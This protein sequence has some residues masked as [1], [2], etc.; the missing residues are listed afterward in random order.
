MSWSKN[1]VKNIIQTITTTIDDGSPADVIYFWVGGPETLKYLF[2]IVDADVVV[3]IDDPME[4]SV[5]WIQ[6]VPEHH[7]A[8]HLVSVISIDKTGVTAS[9]MQEKMRLLMRATVEAAAQG[10][11]YTLKILRETRNS[12]RLG[13]IDLM[14]RTDYYIEYKDA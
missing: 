5:R 14:W 6:D 9:R 11:N 12:S 10:G 3:G 1:V 8:V 13:G 2:Y 7:P 4:A